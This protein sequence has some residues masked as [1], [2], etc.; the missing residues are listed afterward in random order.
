MKV[1]YR[2]ECHQHIGDGQHQILKLFWLLEQRMQ[3]TVGD[4]ELI[5]AVHHMG[6]L[7]CQRYSVADLH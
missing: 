5:P 3:Q 4:Q 2:T 6:S 1:I 7:W